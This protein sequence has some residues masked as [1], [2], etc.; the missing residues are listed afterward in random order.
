MSF[1][2]VFTPE[3]EETYDAL[4]TQLRGRWGENYVDKFESKISKS[5]DRII[6]NP[7]L[8]PVFQ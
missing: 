1:R 4:S 2:I 5:L 7:Y 8:F 6:N 3:A